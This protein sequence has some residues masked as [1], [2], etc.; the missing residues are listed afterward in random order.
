MHDI[1]RFRKALI[2]MDLNHPF[3]EAFG[4]ASTRDDCIASAQAVYHRLLKLSP[5][6][7]VLS[8]SVLREAVLNDDGFV[9]STKKKALKRLFRPDASNEL[10][11][12]AF[13]QCCDNVYKRIRYFRAQVGNSSVI[14]KVLESIIDAIFAFVLGVLVL[15]MLNFNPWPLLVSMSTLMV[16]FAFAVG[17][18]ASK[19][20]EVGANNV[21]LSSKYR[22]LVLTLYLCFLSHFF[23]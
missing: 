19:I 7:T 10:T 1:F 22:L 18:S 5:G 4:P 6:S 20:I 21:L 8:F 17:P 12:I 16:T 14:D 15:S 9:D 23:D 2:F 3:S 13:V 11:L